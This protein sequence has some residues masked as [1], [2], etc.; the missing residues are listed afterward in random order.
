[1]NFWGRLSANVAYSGSRTFTNTYAA[2][3][4]AQINVSKELEGRALEDGQFSFTLRNR[5][6]M[7]IQTVRNDARGNVIF[8]EITYNL[9]QVGTHTYTITE[10][11]DGAAGYTYDSKTITA[12]VEVTDNGDG[13]LSTDITYSPDGV[14]R[15]TY[16][17]EG[18]AA[19][20]VSKELT[21]ETLQAN[22]FSFVL[23][24]ATRSS[25][26]KYIYN[27]RS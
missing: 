27:N 25:W 22:Q 17:A 20:S 16:T 15:N 4:T 5:F 24:D 14:F 11:N 9:S 13:T 8:D 6:G 12:T 21:G 26:N 23:S 2:T 19:I 1:M 3:G 7:P 10:R 18:T